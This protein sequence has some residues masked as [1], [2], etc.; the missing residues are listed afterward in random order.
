MHR[1]VK[2]FGKDLLKGRVNFMSEIILGG[3]YVIENEIGAGGMAIVYKAHDNMLNRTVAIKVLRP[4]FKQDEEFIKRFDIEAKASAGLN[5]PN[6]VG[7]YDVG[8]HEGL[9]YIVMEYIEGITLKELIAKNERLSWQKTLKISSQIC[10]ALAHAHA[11]NVIHRDIKLHNIMVA[12]NGSVKV[13]DFGIARAASAATMTI[14]SKVLGSAHYLSP[15]QARGGFT[16]ERSDIYSLGVCMYEMTVGKVPFDAE[17]TVAVAM[18][19]LQKEPEPPCNLAEDLPKSVEFIILKAMRKR[20]ETRYSS[21]ASMES[22]II[23]V[24]AD[25]NVTLTEE[26]SP[27]AF[28]STKQIDMENETE[29]EKK[30]VNKE[31]HRGIFIGIG[32]AVAALAVFF[33]LKMLLFPASDM[34][35]PNIKG[36]T[37]EQAYEKLA[38]TDEELSIIVRKEEYSD[39]D[40]R[41]KILEQDPE[42]G[43]KLPGTKEIE[44]IIGLGE[45]FFEVDNYVGMNVQKAVKKAEELGLKVSVEKETDDDL[46]ERYKEGV[47]TR[48]SLEPGDEAD[49]DDEITL[50]ES[51]GEDNVLPKMISVVGKSIS[52]AKQALNKAGFDNIETVSKESE[53]EKDTVIEQSVSEGERVDENTHITLIVSAG[54][55]VPSKTDLVFTLPSSPEMMRVKVIRKDNGESVYSRQHAAS[56][57]VSINVKVTGKVTY[58]IYIDDVFWAE[59]SVNS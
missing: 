47:V 59:K 52:D 34:R 19:Q 38:E 8:V 41:D 55:S 51:A 9:H 25:C 37:I 26:D 53:E 18:Q 32:A 14:G 13:M 44:V 21:A 29:D 12:P 50:Y 4:E 3:R 7:V 16:D 27:A 35:M 20:P 56:D 33:V 31:S 49:Y 22:D 48:Q 40:E 58:E 2:A 54:K 30:V 6:I 42:E 39:K 23:R 43:M 45:E 36:L 1:T 10:S 57:T 46:N 24:L 11:R 17:T 28:Y 5:H 15:E